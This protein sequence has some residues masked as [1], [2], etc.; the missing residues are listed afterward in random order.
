M[1]GLPSA[2]RISSARSWTASVRASSMNPAA[3]I[4]IGKAA[5]LHGAAVGQ[6]DEVTVRL[7]TD[8]AAHQPDEVARAARQLEADQVRPEESLEDLSAPRQLA[9]ELGGR[10]GDVEVEADPQVGPELAE[11]LRHQL[12]LVVLH[13]DGG[14]LGGD[15]G[16][17]LGEALVDPDVG[18][19]PLAVEPRLGHQV[20]V[21]R[22]QGAVGE[23]FVEL[24]DL[25]LAQ[26]HRHELEAVLDERLELGV[27]GRP[28]PA[29]PGAVVGPHHRLEGRDQAAGGAAP[30]RSRRRAASRGP[31]AVDWRRSRGRPALIASRF[32]P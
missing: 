11:H 19:P 6:V 3:S 26:V 29:D 10:E 24:L 9:E 25:V 8:A 1:R 22:P 5:R 4:E 30:V 12:E 13:P 14:A 27:V 21:E 7:V 31:P 18:V 23:A 32:P 2:S 15:L 20:V 16:G 28:R 17:A